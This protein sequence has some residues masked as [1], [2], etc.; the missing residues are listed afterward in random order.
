MKKVLFVNSSLTAGG[1]ERVM[2]L[3]TNEFA[4][5]GY[6]VTMVLL[7]EMKPDTYFLDNK[8]WCIRLKYGTKNK[9]IIAV[10][11]FWKLRRILKA[12]KFDSVIAFMHDINIM[13]LL[14]AMGLKQSIIVSERADPSARKNNFVYLKIENYLYSKAK[15]V[16]FQTEQVQNMYPDIVRRRSVVIPNPINRELPIPFEGIREKKIVAVGRLMEQKNFSMLI[17]AFAEINKKHAEYKLVI[18]GGGALLNRLKNEAENLGIK[19]V[20]EFPGYINNVNDEMCNAAMYVSSSNFEGIS[21]AML[22]AMAMGLPT[23]CTDCPVGGTAMMIKNNVNGI[24]IPVGDVKALSDAMCKVIE[25]KKFA[26][27]LSQ[28][29]IKVREEYAVTRIAD[30]WLNLL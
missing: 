7:R 24:L 20:V 3:L 8:V 29:A 5:K 13:T 28:E 23:I 1:S 17:A 15:K 19:T 2:T 30:R 22:E 6:D 4:D 11:R 9:I 14:A 10:K 21:N 27:M 16:V 12:G 25:N 18:F 26:S